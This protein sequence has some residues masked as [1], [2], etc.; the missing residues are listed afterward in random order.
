MSAPELLQ[1]RYSHFNEKARWALDWKGVAH[2][3]TSLLPG[4]HAG[5]V[6]RLTGQ[7]SVPVVVFEDGPVHGS[8]AILEA[9]EERYPN[10]PLFPAEASE[11]A[12]YRELSQHFDVIVAPAARR[13]LFFRLQ[14]DASYMCRMFAEGQPAPR[15]WLYR[16]LLPIAMGKIR[17][18]YQLDD[19]V[20]AKR[21]EEIVLAALDDIASRTRAT[22]YLLGDRFTAADLTAAAI[23]AICCDPPRSTMERPSPQPEALAA[24]TASVSDHPAIAWVLEMYARHREGPGARTK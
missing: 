20:A 5:R 12:A 21:A 15:R 7:T 19:P 8:A 16:A 9:L 11:L 10:P 2:E 6:R 4:P 3:C 1:F 23:L 24:W 17:N 14:H 22:G 13:A 18:A